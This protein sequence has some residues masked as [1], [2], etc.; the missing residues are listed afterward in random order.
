MGQ[1]RA[2]QRVPIALGLLAG[3]QVA[4]GCATAERRLARPE[5][6]EVV[7]GQGE[8]ETRR[9]RDA[10]IESLHRAAPGTDWRVIERA[11]WR[12]HLEARNAIRRARLA[13]LAAPDALPWMEVGSFNLAGRTHQAA[14]HA[15]TRSLYLGSN[16]GGL[17]RG[18]FDP[19][20][21][22]PSKMNWQP[23]SDGV[24]G[25]AFQVLVLDEP[26]T[27]LLKTNAEASSSQI[28]RSTDGGAT[29][30]IAAGVTGRVRRLLKLRNAGQTIFAI[31]DTP[32]QWI[33]GE[34]TTTTLLRSVD[35]G[36]TFQVVRN[37]G[38]SRA[39]IW[40]SRTASGPLYVLT[41]NRLDISRDRGTT[42]TTVGTLPWTGPSRVVLTASEA[43]S[44]TFYTVI[45][46]NDCSG[47]RTMFKSVDGGVSWVQTG[48]V[49]D[50]WGDMVSLSASTTDPDLLLYGGVEAWR[51]TN[52]GSSF[53]RVN[54]WFDYYGDPAHKL[55]ADVPS[56][57]FVPLAGGGEVLFVATDG[58][59]FYSADGGATFDNLSRHGLNVG[60]YYST[61]SDAADPRLIQA[62]SQ[63]QGYQA[64]EA[65]QGLGFEQLISGDYGQ[66]T[67]SSGTHDLV[68]AVNPEFILA[69]EKSGGGTN[70]HHEIDFPSENAHWLPCLVA[71]PLDPGSV[72]LCAQH[73]HKYT[74]SGSAWART[75]L[76]FD[77]ASVPGE[78][79]SAFAIAPSDS[80]RWYVATT[81]NRILYSSDGGASWSVSAFASVPAP[82]YLTG[83]AILV[84]P[85][86]PSTVTV[87][88][89]GYSNAPVYRS[90]DGGQTFWPLR[91]GLPGTLI[92]D[93]AADPLRGPDLYAA[94]ENGPYRYD[95]AG[96]VWQSLLG[97][98]A[99]MTVYWS[100]EPAVDR[101]RFGTYGRGIWDYVP[102]QPGCSFSVSPAAAS[103]S[104]AGGTGALDVS[105]TD[106]CAWSATRLDDWIELTG[107]TKGIG[108]GRVEYAV[109]AS[110]T[111][112]IRTGHISLRDRTLTV[113]QGEPP[114][115]VVSFTAASYA[116][117]ESGGMAT[118]GVTRTGPAA[119]AVT[120]HYATGDLSAVAG[121]DY[122]ARSGTL[123]FGAGVTSR[124][125]TVPITNDTLDE[126]NETLRLTLTAAGGGAVLGALTQATLT[127]GDD[128]VAGTLQLTRAAISV[129]E[130]GAQAT[131]TVRRTGGAA[132]G[133]TAQYQAVGGTADAS[134][135]TS[136]S[137]TLAFGAGLNTGSFTVPIRNDAFDESNE[138]VQ[139]ALTGVGG[140]GVLGALRAATLTIVD[141]DTAGVLQLSRA[142]YSVTEGAGSAL[143]TVT[144]K[145]GAAAGVGV[146]YTTGDGTATEGADYTA[147]SGFLTFGAGEVTK[148]FL[149]PILA[150]ALAES[151]ETIILT[152]SAPTGGARLG[153]RVK[154]TLTIRF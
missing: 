61:L 97:D 31:T 49:G 10:W 129:N 124:S 18:S 60:Q 66:L 146:S 56:I 75:Q 52:G 37:L 112:G 120:V 125:F 8:S 27:T 154:A 145:G 101:V 26:P 16:L 48:L 150:D 116:A 147:S 102:P 144:R 99:P 63:D 29:W 95:S 94:T 121:S 151:N 19:A 117:T 3:L 35:R 6:T 76:P 127:I 36:A 62:G 81:H 41:D 140:G 106:G 5:P 142:A 20:S 22:D 71:D 9:R 105:A 148:T 67:S 80:S 152:L 92:Y 149:V 4:I 40:T 135:Y 131:V 23:L 58:G 141:N 136:V 119:A 87:G 84:D 11:N 86:D 69:A 122:A 13:G 98:S 25:S 96:G 77:F 104:Y 139:V 143:I 153:A 54:R 107:T 64:G 83:L 17:W 42:W 88:G 33:C 59:T 34:A 126:D 39:D 85:S 132:S 72:Y 70:L 108:N 32:N 111:P 130:A 38:G 46:K 24:H 89:S 7:T 65:G 15:A 93:L 109:A 51:S 73:L 78:H 44:P 50:F 79:V 113:T 100:V 53:T 103:F 123:A 133:V 90:T 43:G 57:D 74:R 30:T 28:H 12:K 118:I 91:S 82:Q 137:G 68:Y 134:D 55:H 128:D 138:T 21:P 47:S 1:R 14:F 110:T 2:L 114:P 45:Q 115:P